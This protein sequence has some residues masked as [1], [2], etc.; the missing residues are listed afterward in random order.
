MLFNNT[1]IESI[2]NGEVLLG[3]VAV[4]YYE[5]NKAS[6]LEDYSP[7]VAFLVVR[8]ELTRQVEEYEHFKFA[9]QFY[10]YRLEAIK[11]SIVI[12]DNFSELKNLYKSISQFKGRQ[13]YFTLFNPYLNELIDFVER[14]ISLYGKTLAD[15]MIYRGLFDSYYYNYFIEN[16]EIEEDEV[17]SFAIDQVRELVED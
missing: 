3:K 1:Q 12:S 4:D 10:Q 14:I 16:K 13:I 11:E 6:I 17:L 2:V 9:K 7:E 5:E 15:C 8:G